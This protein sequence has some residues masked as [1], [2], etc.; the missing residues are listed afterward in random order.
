MSD[1]P[2][3]P[4]SQMPQI[5]EKDV[6]K[7]IVFMTEAGYPVIDA[8]RRLQP[9][10]YHQDVDWKKAKAMPDTV[11]AKPVLVTRDDELIDGNH[12]SAR[13]EID[14]T[15]TPFIRFNVSFVEALDILAVAPFAYELT[16][17][18]PERN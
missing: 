17:A 13:H 1:D 8:G 11:L 18:T 16:P 10:V 14:G 3:V 7:L 9:F 12:R 15:R 6:A 4:R 2:K 5:D